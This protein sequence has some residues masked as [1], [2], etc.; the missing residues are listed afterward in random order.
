[1]DGLEWIGSDGQA[2]PALLSTRRA[3]AYFLLL[4][5]FSHAGSLPQPTREKAVAFIVRFLD[6]PSA[7]LRRAATQLLGGHTHYGVTVS[8]GSLLIYM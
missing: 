4:T 7:E 6:S 5:A 1:V 3:A 2:T 8:R